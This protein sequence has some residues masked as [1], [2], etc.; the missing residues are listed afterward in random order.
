MPTWTVVD[1]KGDPWLRHLRDAVKEDGY[2]F[3]ALT[4]ERDL[5]VIDAREREDLPS[6]ICLT[7]Q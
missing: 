5:K 7:Y 4:A 6:A 3:N 2:T 1:P